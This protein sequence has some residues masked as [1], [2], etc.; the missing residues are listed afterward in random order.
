MSE[1]DEARP[2]DPDE[3]A[4]LLGA[5]ERF[6]QEVP[7]LDPADLVRRTQA[8]ESDLEAFVPMHTEVVSLLRRVADR[9][10]A[11]LD[12]LPDVEPPTPRPDDG[13]A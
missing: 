9:A 8:F 1:D 5:L 13:P 7:H 11:G 6:A 12:Q 10:A 2:V 4:R 3:Y